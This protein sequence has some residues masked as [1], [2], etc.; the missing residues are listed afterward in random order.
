MLRNIHVLAFTHRQLEV[1]QIGLLHIGMDKQQERLS[2]LKVN[3]DL[4]ELLFLSTCNLVA[5]VF[6]TQQEVDEKFIQTFITHLYPEFREESITLFCQNYEYYQEIN[7]VKHLL[8]VASS[9]DSMVVGEREII[10]QVRKSFDSCRKF[11]L[12]GD[13]IRLLIRFT[14]ESAKR[15]YTETNISQ[16]AVSV[17]SLAYQTL[18]NKNIPLDARVL[19]V[20]AGVTNTNMLRFLKEHGFV[21]FVVFN[22]TVE[23]ADALAADVGGRGFPLSDLRNYKEG[24]DVIIT[25]TGAEE[26][27]ITPEIY[28]RL[29]QGDTSEKTVIDLA[30]PHDLDPVIPNRHIVEHISI[31]Y[32]QN[33]SRKNI[34]ERTKEIIYVEHIIAEAVLEFKKLAKQRAVEVAMREVP[35][36]VK[37]IRATALEQ[38]FAK[39][40]SQLDGESKETVE[41]IIDYL[42]KKYIS[43]PMRMAKDILLNAE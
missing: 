19:V 18:E 31:D 27:V 36:K 25:C 32:L 2:N 26:A 28:E 40:L 13:S 35:E 12:T 34:K 29:L 42:E 16:R 11:G 5:F 24:F 3:S 4:E 14:I 30:I 10:T 41:K 15:I 17:V 21:N 8:K 9:V 22:R 7:A 39:E 23:K 43:L 20:G 1:S 33:L 37:E 6:K 38:V